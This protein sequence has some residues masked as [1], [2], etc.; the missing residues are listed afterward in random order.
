L[1]PLES[2]ELIDRMNSHRSVRG[3]S[4]E[5]AAGAVSGRCRRSQLLPLI[6]FLPRWINA[7]IGGGSSEIRNSKW[8]GG[9]EFRIHHSEFGI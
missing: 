1:A 2:E 3:L 7:S 9:R 4:L 5:S 6:T 8:L